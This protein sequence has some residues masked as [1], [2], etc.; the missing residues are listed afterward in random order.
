[1]TLSITCRAFLLSGSVET[2][3]KCWKSTN[4]LLCCN[5]KYSLS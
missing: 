4:F 5:Q 1:M 2:N 3:E